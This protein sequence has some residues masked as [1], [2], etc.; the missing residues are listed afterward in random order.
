VTVPTATTGTMSNLQRAELLLTR[1][2]LDLAA[3]VDHDQA[4]AVLAR[5]LRRY[6]PFTHPHGRLL[7][8]ACHARSPADKQAGSR[9]AEEKAVRGLLR[10][11]ESPTEAA[12][13]TRA[14]QTQR[15]ARTQATRGPRLDRIAERDAAAAVEVV[16]GWWRRYGRPLPPVTLGRRFG[17]AGDTWPVIRRLQVAG[18]PSRAAGYVLGRGVR[19]RRGREAAAKPRNKGRW[20]QRHP[21]LGWGCRGW[22]WLWRALGVPG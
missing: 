7:V 16:V 1:A 11:G 6:D 2:A 12:V 4:V 13:A 8:A 15:R 14:E 19:I 9:P 5:V 18:W 22:W 10:I 20:R 21:W 3:G 17:W